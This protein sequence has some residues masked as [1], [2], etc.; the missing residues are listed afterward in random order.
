MVEFRNGHTD[1]IELRRGNLAAGHQSSACGKVDQRT[2]EASKISVLFCLRGYD[3]CV[4]DALAVA[5]SS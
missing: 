3:R 5:E 1:G 2:G 4:R